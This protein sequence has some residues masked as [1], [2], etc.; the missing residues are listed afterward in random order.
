MNKGDASYREGDLVSKKPSLYTLEELALK[1]SHPSMTKEK[2]LL[3]LAKATRPLRLFEVSGEIGK[4][5]ATI[6]HHLRQ[7]LEMG[8]VEQVVIDGIKA[9]TLSEIGTQLVDKFFLG[10]M[11]EEDLL[12][13]R[14]RELAS[15]LGMAVNSEEFRKL[16]NEVEKWYSETKKLIGPKIK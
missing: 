13:V 12:D 3:A 5:K 2:L 14:I 10:T 15:K 9:Y 11:K 1:V 7:L 16:K 4:D 8:I 6:D